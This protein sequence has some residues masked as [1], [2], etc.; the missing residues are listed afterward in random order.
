VDLTEEHL[1]SKKKQPR[2]ESGEDGTEGHKDDHQ[3]EKKDD[4]H[5][6]GDKEDVKNDDELYA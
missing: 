3:D 4:D 2:V 1:E 6:E 5:D